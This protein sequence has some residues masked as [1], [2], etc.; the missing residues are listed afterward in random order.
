MPLMALCLQ[1]CFMTFVAITNKTGESIAVTSGHTHET[2][3][4]ARNCTRSIPHTAGDL[5]IVTDS[6]QK[7]T[8]YNV[9]AL[10]G[11]KCRHF[12]FWKKQVKDLTIEKPKQ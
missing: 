8:E 7:W 2:Y 3:D 11:K 5:M 4:I 12:I 9:S 6:G 1:G 10:D